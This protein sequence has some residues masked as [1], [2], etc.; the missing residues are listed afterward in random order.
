MSNKNKYRFGVG[1][2]KKFTDKKL[3]WQLNVNWQHDI[4]QH[5][6]RTNL[7]VFTVIEQ[8]GF[9]LLCCFK[10]LVGVVLVVKKMEPDL[11][12]QQRRS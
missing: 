9:I 10:E 2:L 3:L 11:V 8:Q 1:L 4:K 7:A 12:E 6:E 5:L